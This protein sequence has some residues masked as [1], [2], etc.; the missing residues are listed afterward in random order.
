MFE[1]FGLYTA[2]AFQDETRKKPP[3]IENLTETY[4]L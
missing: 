1:S 2:E 4:K 3:T